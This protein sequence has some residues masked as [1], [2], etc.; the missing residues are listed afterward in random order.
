MRAKLFPVVLAILLLFSILQAQ[1]NPKPT[2]SPT[3]AAPAKADDCGCDVPLPEVLAT[4]N[5]VNITRQELTANQARIKELQEHV[6]KARKQELDLQI[7]SQLLDEEAKKRGVTTAKILEEEVVAKVAEPTEAEAL[8]FF[9]QNKDRIP[10]DFATMKKEVIDYLRNQ[11]QTEQAKLFADRLRAAAQIKLSG[12]AVSP[13]ASDADLARVFVTV[14]GKNITS[15]DVEYTLKP[16]V[17]SVQDQV[18]ALRKS[19]VDVKINDILLVQEATKR[20]TSTKALLDAEVLAKVPPISEAQAQKFYD[21]NKERLSGDFATVKVQL[22]EYLKEKARTEQEQVFADRL[23]SAA[24]VR[25]F[26]TPPIP[27]QASKPETPK[28]TP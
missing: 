11:R 17:T 19:E 3:P 5:G 26:L 8:A 24:T 20:A 10:G 27:P 4:V 14:N 15:G 21:E 12:I 18:Y 25:I 7:N 22:I 16:L 2:A 1:T 6:T 28:T 9:E 23:R 13:P